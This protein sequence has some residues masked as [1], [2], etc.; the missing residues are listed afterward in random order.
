MTIAARNVGNQAPSSAPAGRLP[1]QPSPGHT[2]PRPLRRVLRY[3]GMCYGVLASA[4]L[5]AIALLGDG[6]T[7]T[8]VLALLYFWWLCPAPLVLVLALAFRS[9]RVVATAVIPAVAAVYLLG[10]YLVNM[11]TPRSSAPADLR[12]ATF[13][14]TN[15]RPLDGLMTLVADYHPDVLLLQ[16]VTATQAQ[17]PALLPGYPYASAAPKSPQHDSSAVVSRFP[18]LSTEPVTRLPAGARPADLV[19]IDVHGRHVAFLSV[20]L[21]SPCIGCPAGAGAAGTTG[22]AAQLRIAEAARYAQLVARLA[23]GGR[24]VVLGGDLNSSPMN[25]PLHELTKVGLVDTARVAGRGLDFTRGPGP[26]LA[27]VDVVLVDGF[28]ALRVVDGSPGSSTHSPVIADLAWPRS[29]STGHH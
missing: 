24:P 3:L 8:Y 13:N 2:R 29:R 11:A 4:A 5:L 10:P 20:H 25:Q 6:T 23:R 18:I 12:V 1:G 21:A 9:P 17:L 16:E 26:G 22:Q 7:S 15:A 27:R 28:D 14:L 19:T